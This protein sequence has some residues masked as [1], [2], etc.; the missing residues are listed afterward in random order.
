MF[1]NSIQLASINIRGLRQKDKRTA[2]FTSFK[3]QGFEFIFLQEVFGTENERTSWENDWEGSSFWNMYNS[4]EA[5][6]GILISHRVDYSVVGQKTDT[7]GRI[8]AVTIEYSAEKHRINLVNVYAPSGGSKNKERKDFLLSLSDYIVDDPLVLNILAGDFN[9]ITDSDLDCSPSRPYTDYSG[10]VLNKQIKSLDLEDIWRTFHPDE[11]GFTFS[12]ASGSQSRV[13]RIH[14]SRLY[15]NSVIC[16]EIEPFPLAPDHSMVTVALCLDPVV[17]GR[18]FW[19]LNTSLLDEQQYRDKVTSFWTDWR[20]RKQQFTTLGAWWDAGKF[21][22]KQMSITHAIKKKQLSRQYEKKLQKQLRNT[23]RKMD[24]LGRESDATRFHSIKSKLE[25]IELEKARGIII[26][27]RAEWHESGE[28]ATKHFLNHAKK[29]A[30]DNT[31][32]GV[33]TADG[34]VVTDQI[35]LLSEHV[36]FY[37]ELYAKD[38]TEESAQDACFASL[39]AKLSPEAKQS[40]EGLITLKQ[41]EDAISK[42]QLNKSPGIDGLPI[43]FYKRF[44]KAIGQ[45]YV[46]M[47]NECFERQE[48][49]ESQKLA[50]ISTLFKKGDRLSLKNWRPIS[51]LNC[52]Y[53]ILSKI[54]SIRLGNVIE[55]I[56]SSDQT[57]GIPGRSISHNLLL[58]KDL[59]AYCNERDLPA[60]IISID[61]MKAFDRVNWEFLFKTLQKFNFGPQFIQWIKI[62]YTDV[63]SCV[64]VNN[65]ISEPFSL[66]KGVRQGCALSPLLY[67]LVAEVLACMIRED[68]DIHGIPLP[69]TNEHCK[70]SQYADDT[71]LTLLH[72]NSIEKAFTVLDTYGKA[73]GAKVNLDKCEGLTVGS[74]RSE[75]DFPVT[76]KWTSTKIK[77]LGVYLGNTDTTHDNW[78]PRVQKFRKVLNL[79]KSRK[80]SLKGKATVVNQLAM[81][82]LLYTGSVFTLPDWAY[83]LI[84]ESIWEFFWGGKSC[85]VKKTTCQLP[86][87]QGGYNMPDLKMKLES[88]RVKYIQ[89]LLSDTPS[90]WRPLAFYF[91][92]KYDVIPYGRSIFGITP[93]NTRL[94]NLS[95]FYSSILKTWQAI[96]GKRKFDPQTTCHSSIMNELIF[97]RHIFDSRTGPLRF[98]TWIELGVLRV[99]GIT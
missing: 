39:K 12:S 90:K 34:T 38:E 27:A 68:K 23:K 55:Q 99:R 6:V 20:K 14:T 32:R 88:L 4:R 64:K 54:L 86:L 69:D 89:L 57:C 5:G 51:L 53:K 18:G 94:K 98:K 50:V 30:S 82:I 67:V 11:K 84:E 47:L 78:H 7:S 91:L 61:Q 42:F 43:E 28:N 41:C 97:N 16:T 9:C 40:C 73:S 45:D 81:S 31:I 19:K 85:P 49:T 21:K 26:R 74:F 95:P 44:W 93:S 66:E 56:V 79:W 10:K 17:R 76:F 75:T 77:L 22:I 8:L 65:F 29:K 83:K 35:G 33:K 71:S 96:G 70:I 58:L 52:D 92:N 87:N 59:I 72:K 15:R 60:V 46:D 1:I 3:E 13:D 48:M 2:C 62:L 80:L 37:K 63:K 24:S 36:K 25:Q